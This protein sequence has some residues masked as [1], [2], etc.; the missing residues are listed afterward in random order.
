[1]AEETTILK[2]GI[3]G[4]G[5]KQGAS[6]FKGA[7]N[8]I[9]SDAKSLLKDLKQ[10]AKE[11]FDSIFNLQN[12]IAGLGAG[13]IIKGIIDTNVEFQRLNASLLTVTGSSEKAA[14][15]FAGLQ[16]FAAETPF[17]LRGLTE[18]FT[19]LQLSGLEASE[20]ALTSY[21]NIAAS[22]G[23][24]ITEIARAMKSAMSGEFEALSS[25]GPKVTTVGGKYIV[26][27]QGVRTE[28]EKSGK[29]LEDFVLHLGETTFAGGMANQMQTLAGQWSNFGD[30]VDRLTVQIGEGGFNQA[31]SELIQHFLKLSSGGDDVAQTIGGILGD[32]VRGLDAALT[33]LI[34]HW[35]IF[36]SIITGVAV[37]AMVALTAS[38]VSGTA[39]VI[40]YGVAWLLTPWG[41]ILGAITAL[42]AAIVYF[43]DETIE[44][45]GHSATVGD[46]I[47][48]V[49][50]HVAEAVGDAIDWLID[51]LRNMVD[52]FMNQSKAASK[53]F[54]SP[55]DNTMKAITNTVRKA[56]N[57]MIG[58]F[59]SF[60][61][62]AS[63]AATAAKDA[64]SG[65]FHD[66]NKEA[67]EAFKKNME[68]DWLAKA[69]GSPEQ[70]GAA[71]N[72]VFDQWGKEAE[73]IRKD[74]EAAEKKREE[75]R[76][77]LEALMNKG[78]GG[79]GSKLSDKKDNTKEIQK[80]IKELDHMRDAL[81]GVENDAKVSEIALA[82]FMKYGDSPE[83]EK[84]VAFKRDYNQIT[85]DGTIPITK[86]ETARLRAATDSIVEN[87]KALEKQKRIKEKDKD[88]AKDITRASWEKFTDIKMPPGLKDIQ[89]QL[90]NIALELDI[91]VQEAEKFRDAL[92]FIAKTR[93]EI[94]K[95]EVSKN[96]TKELSQLQFQAALLGKSTVE[97]Q[98]QTMLRELLLELQEKGITYT[99]EELEGWTEQIGKIAEAQQKVARLSSLASFL[100][101]N[102]DLVKSLADFS[103]SAIDQIANAWVD[104]TETGKLNF[105]EFADFVYQEIT[106]I[107][108]KFLIAKAVES[109]IGAFGGGA[110]GGANFGIAAVHHQGGVVGG[111]GMPTRSVHSGAFASAKRYGI[112]GIPGLNPGEVPIIAH[113][114]EAVVPLPSGKGIP[115]DLKGMGQKG[116]DNINISINGVKDFD[117]FRRNS[118]A[119]AAET[120]RALTARQ[121]RD[122]T[123]RG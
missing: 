43:S 5:A 101:E 9:K 42:T 28:I 66:F 2:V 97:M 45:G 102:N 57:Y 110:A 62:A 32:A 21:G 64:F 77:K 40:A 18:A 56:I 65:K 15:A 39:A 1:M 109:T 36:S 112:G 19:T 16:K 10:N 106:K 94:R 75:E 120:S 69:F 31:L 24:D 22:F 82:E 70:I 117:S 100:E 98:K 25:F 111:S 92:E 81:K 3:N 13:A 74:R 80:A 26:T 119:L 86:E 104:F 41:A 91:S 17:S 67:D 14:A 115:V 8:S 11:I 78:L 55:W 123:R 83:A 84:L 54:A 79:F 99:Q 96:Y 105:K 48:V 107:I 116:G 61:D 72:M 87:T 30:N 60:G 29:A 23:R 37:A 90:V 47:M 34:D 35:D 38:V 108:I 103:V 85:K 118:G 113:R 50:N 89:M 20:K 44:V 7:T 95:I 63:L 93:G 114:K 59:V 4:Q 68:T 53:M 71:L 121:R 27:F 52:E 88:I 58:F 46:Y 76:K 73:E 12:L 49:W 122:G 51:Q 6:D 33:F